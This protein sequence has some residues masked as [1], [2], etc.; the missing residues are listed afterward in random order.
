[1]PTLSQ[2]PS[3]APTDSEVTLYIKIELDDNPQEIG[4]FV[5][6]A[7]YS[8]FRVAVPFGAYVSSMKVVNDQ[9]YVKGGENYQFV[10]S[11]SAGNGLS[12]G[13]SY[14]VYLGEQF[15]YKM[16][17]NGSGDFGANETTIFYVPNNIARSAPSKSPAAPSPAPST[18]PPT[19]RSATRGILPTSAPTTNTPTIV[20][21]S[22]CVHMMY[23][24]L[25]LVTTVVF[26][27]T[28]RHI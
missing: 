2:V 24:P 15:G 3:A 25:L 14:K 13:G 17:A 23:I 5:A 12:D 1:M 10:I 27:A 21:S 22:G 19:P 16:L 4:W 7:N 9:V 6:D 11:D 20:Q 26:V 8:R 28:I 18:K